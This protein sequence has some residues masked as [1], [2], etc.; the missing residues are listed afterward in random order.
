[1]TRSLSSARAR[2]SL[3]IVAVVAAAAPV[4]AS[5]GCSDE[6]AIENLCGWVGNPD[7]CY[8]AFAEDIGDRCG[9]A[10]Q[11][12]APVGGFLARDKLDICILSEGGQVIFDPPLDLAA[13]PLKTA[14][15]KLIDG[16]GAQC[17]S[18][19]LGGELSFSVTVDGFPPDGGAPGAG[20]AG[21]G[22]GAGGEVVK[23]GTFTS[24]KAPDRDVFDVSCPTGEAHHFDRLQIGECPEYAALLPRAELESSAGGIDI[25]GHVVFRVFYPPIEGAL[26]GAAPT[27]V[28]YFDCSFPGA[29]KPCEDGVRGGEETDVDC[30]GSTCAACQEGQGCIQGSDCASGVCALEMGLKKCAPGSASGAGGAGGAGSGGAPAGGAGGAGGTG[31]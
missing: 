17:G 31:G 25:P 23:G 16:N 18:G 30:G 5:K 21:A 26:E 24:S 27:V 8:R 19:S 22:G 15:F 3:S 9:R 28:E 4:I 10:G 13:F 11:G 2:V 1:V 6:A 7:N 20:G 14:A 29:P 12:S